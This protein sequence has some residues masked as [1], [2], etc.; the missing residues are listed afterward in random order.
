MYVNIST[1]PT[2]TTTIVTKPPYMIRGITV[3]STRQRKLRYFSRIPKI[4]WPY[5]VS[6]ANQ[7]V[8]NK[9]SVLAYYEGNGGW[10]LYFLCRI[11][12]C[13]RFCYHSFPA[14]HFFLIPR[15]ST[16]LEMLIVTQLVR[17]VPLLGTCR[18]MTVI[19]KRPPLYPTI[20]QKDPIHVHT[21]IKIYSNVI[22]PST[23]RY[24]SLCLLFRFPHK[25]VT[26]ICRL[27]GFDV[28]NT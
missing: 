3:L 5:Q 12:T 8:W 15:G 6:T 20:S 4:V 21:E 7:C 13:T 25:N 17:K 22:L 2:T 14:L 18:F 28:S 27:R 10:G 26:F 9:S 23:P 11:K 24:A 16:Q 1:S 19:T